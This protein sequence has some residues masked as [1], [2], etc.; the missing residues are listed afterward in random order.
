MG[1][2][3]SSKAFRRYLVMND[4]A[5]HAFRIRN[6]EPNDGDEEDD[7]GYEVKEATVWVDGLDR[8]HK[9]RGIIAASICPPR[10]SS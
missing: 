9:A 4:E 1:Q 8:I 6:G 2:E 10:R 7:D 3:A 5:H